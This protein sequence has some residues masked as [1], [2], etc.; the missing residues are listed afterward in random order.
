MIA[1]GRRV[2]YFAGEVV[3]VEWSGERAG[4]AVA[5]AF[6]RAMQGD[7]RHPD[8]VFRLRAHD[9]SPLLALLCGRSRLYRGDSLGAATHLLVQHVLDSLIRTSSGGVVFHAGLLG[10]AGKGVLLPGASGSGKTMLSA[11]LALQSLE[12]L[13]DEACYL[14]DAAP[15]AEGFARPFFFKGAWR[16]VLG[17]EG[18]DGCRILRDDGVTLV[19]SE[20]LSAACDGSV[21]EPR[22]IVFPHFRR[23]AS[24]ELT[25]LSPARTAVRLVATVANAR[26]LPD[27]GIARVAELARA[28]ATY[29]LTYGSFAQLDPLLRLIDSLS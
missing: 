26:N 17:V 6:G 20:L 13:S 22:L 24:F 2:V 1:S 15:L 8:V 12:Y 18:I 10:R 11:W 14:T 23:G 3:G 29:D 9:D 28:A 27:H 16:D 7:Q 5:M 19:P 21:I 4:Q 25:R